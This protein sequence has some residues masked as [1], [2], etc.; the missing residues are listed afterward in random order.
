M[1][2][3]FCLSVPWVFLVCAMAETQKSVKIKE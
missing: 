1:L 3:A 2:K